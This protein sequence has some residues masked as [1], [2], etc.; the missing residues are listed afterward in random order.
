MTDRMAP[1]MCCLKVNQKM[2]ENNM[3]VKRYGKQ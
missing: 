2:Y 1:L 3:E